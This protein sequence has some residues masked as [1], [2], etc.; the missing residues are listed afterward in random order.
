[1]SRIGVAI[2]IPQ[3]WSAQL[4]AARVESGD[5]LAGSVPPHVTLLQPTDVAEVD[6]SV[7]EEHLWAVAAG[8]HPFEIHL[9]GTGTFRPVTDVV[10][11]TVARGISECELLEAAIRRGPL[12][13]ETKYP[14]HPHVTVAHDVAEA[15]L[16]RAYADLSSFDARFVVDGFTLFE[17]GPD[18]H[19]RPET[20]FPFG[21]SAP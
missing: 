13:G 4:D 8:H 7:V 14:Y 12:A 1:M 18:G 10:F 6:R 2:G 11:V 17:H 20:E 9:H 16:D 19:W 3:P 5:V 15:S 21:L